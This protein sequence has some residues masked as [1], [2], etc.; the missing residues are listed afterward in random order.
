MSLQ[1]EKL[2]LIEW[3]INVKDA[4][5]IKEFISLKNKKESDWWDELSQEQKE[6]IEAGLAD[7]DSG[8]KREFKKVLDRL[9]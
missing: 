3:L 8:K 5:V 7:L 4:R 1:S 2:H 6:D 9:R